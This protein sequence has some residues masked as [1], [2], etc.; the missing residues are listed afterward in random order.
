MVN[1]ENL[2]IEAAAKEFAAKGFD[3]ARTTAIAARAGVTHAMLHYYFRT[4]EQLFERIT[5]DIFSTLIEMMTTALTQ[6]G[7]TLKERIAAGVRAH[8]DFVS[9]HREVPLFVISA[10]HSSPAMM[11]SFI[12]RIANG[13]GVILTEIQAELDKAADAGLIC[14]VDALMLL[15]D[16]VSLNVFPFLTST[17]LCTAFDMNDYEAFLTA[18]REENVEI[19]MKRLQI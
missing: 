13:A 12:S 10:L 1:T 18:K 11:Q 2:I 6:P 15:I 5:G 16:M 19:I 8:F 7:L 3:G 4:K 9:L 17:M 14:H